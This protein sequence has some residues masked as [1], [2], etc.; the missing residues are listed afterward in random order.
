MANRFRLRSI[1][2]AERDIRR[3]IHQ[4]LIHQM[5][6][7]KVLSFIGV[8]GGGLPDRFGRPV[9]HYRLWYGDKMD[10]SEDFP[11]LQVFLADG[12]VALIEVK[13]HGKKPTAGQEAYLARHQGVHRTGVAFG[14]EDVLRIC[15]L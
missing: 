10:V 4:A 8:N 9:P 1:D 2:P 7:G 6:L 5:N 14:Y 12:T 15:G 3:Q 13:R 11:D